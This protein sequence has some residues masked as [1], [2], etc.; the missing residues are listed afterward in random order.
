M[1]ILTVIGALSYFKHR[2]LVLEKDVRVATST[3][4]TI[5]HLLIFNHHTVNFL[6]RQTKCIRCTDTAET[7]SVNICCQALKST[8]RKKKKPT[9]KTKKLLQ[10]V[11]KFTEIKGVFVCL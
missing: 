6:L 5:L 10:Q 9:Q 7:T 11:I 8:W 1:L 3:G 2:W 4:K